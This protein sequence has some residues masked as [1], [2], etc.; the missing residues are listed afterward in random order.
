MTRK[1]KA[2]VAVGLMATLAI[3][4]GVYLWAAP[5]RLE[6]G[7]AST[8]REYYQE[9]A[10][11]QPG[12]SAQS[13]DA[14]VA[15]LLEERRVLDETVWAKEVAAQKYEE[16]IVKY[17]DRMLRP[18]DDKYAVLAEFPF[19]TI[20]MAAAG[21]TTELDWGI[22]RTTFRGQGKPV[23]R[24]EWHEY[25]R[26]MKESGRVI[27]SIEF[28]QSAFEVDALGN[29]VSVFDMSLNVVNQ[30]GNHRWSVQSKLRVEWTDERDKDGHYIAGDLTLFDTTILEREGPPVFEH[31]VFESMIRPGS[32]PIV[33]D[34]NRDGFSDILLPATNIAMWNRGDGNFDS[35]AL[36]MAEDI[37]PPST[38]SSSIAAD[39]TLD[40]FVDLLCIGRYKTASADDSSSPEL[41]VY[42][43]RGNDAGEFLMPGLRVASRA[44][45]LVNPR[46]VTAGDID[47]DGDLDL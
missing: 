8:M 7:G 23:D 38:V 30:D 36:F 26:E 47:G 3:V 32:Y 43:F 41:G 40:G 13:L 5:A 22:K 18:Q 46:S 24:E 29:A 35:R 34:L 33:V 12:E 45:A 2:I 39:F 4:A 27:R 16:T 6:S 11:V 19:Q 31:R 20:S 37:A 15:E 9:R 21:E 44:L 25:L 1:S 17:W 14:E 10:G 42:L 28:H